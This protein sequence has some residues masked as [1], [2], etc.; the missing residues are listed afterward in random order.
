M[1]SNKNETPDVPT[2]V[3]DVPPNVR[4]HLRKSQSNKENLP[5]KRKTDK[6]KQ[7][8]SSEQKKGGGFFGRKS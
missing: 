4:E 3:P 2:N 6:R 7:R 1:T 5:A 8:K